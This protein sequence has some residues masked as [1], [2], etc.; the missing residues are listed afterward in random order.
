MKRLSDTYS[1]DKIKDK[2]TEEERKQLKQLQTVADH[3]GEQMDNLLRYATEQKAKAERHSTSFQTNSSVYTDTQGNRYVFDM[4]KAEYSENEG[5]ILHL[6]PADEIK[7]IETDELV[8]NLE[9]R[10][11]ELN[12]TEGKSEEDKI[13]DRSLANSL[14]GAID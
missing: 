12:E 4:S 9:N 5:L 3:L 10:V 11:K 2:T 1:A 6:R 14:Q 7:D 13:R 8:K